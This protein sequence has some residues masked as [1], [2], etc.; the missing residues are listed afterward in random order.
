[1]WPLQKTNVTSIA[2]GAFMTASTREILTLL[3]TAMKLRKPGERLQG[4][5]WDLQRELLPAHSTLQEQP[6]L[7]YM[8]LASSS[9][10]T[11]QAC[12]PS[13]LHGLYTLALTQLLL[14]LSSVVGCMRLSILLHGCPQ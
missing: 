10:E 4:W 1:M 14:V 9:K 5:V 12:I 8:A 13:C 6:C 3:K 2:R 7:H 11:L